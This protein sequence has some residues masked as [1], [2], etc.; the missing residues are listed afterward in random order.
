MQVVRSIGRQLS[1]ALK[2]RQAPHFPTA[3]VHVGLAQAGDDL[4]ERVRPDPTNIPTWDTVMAG[5]R[6]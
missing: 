2:Q 5:A 6:G 3:R 4:F 1:N